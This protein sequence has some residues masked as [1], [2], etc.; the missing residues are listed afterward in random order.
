MWTNFRIQVSYD[1]RPRHTAVMLAN[2][3]SKNKGRDIQVKCV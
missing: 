3:I 1:R 2:G